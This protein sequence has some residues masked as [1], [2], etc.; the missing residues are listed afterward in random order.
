MMLQPMYFAYGYDWEDDI[1]ASCK[2]FG[3]AYFNENETTAL[4]EEND[5]ADEASMFSK[6]IL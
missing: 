6:A 5:A 1:C 4:I 2:S 3:L